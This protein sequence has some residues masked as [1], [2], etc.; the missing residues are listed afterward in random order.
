MLHDHKGALT[1]H[2][3][4][5]FFQ[6]FL[7]QTGS[8]QIFDLICHIW[9]CLPCRNKKIDCETFSEFGVPWEQ[10]YLIFSPM[11]LWTYLSWITDPTLALLV[12]RLLIYFLLVG[13]ILKEE[14]PT[15]L[16]T[17]KI[18]EFEGYWKKNA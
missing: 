9:I 18:S 13:G 1:I 16:L 11:G 2:R 4:C 3:L 12:V 6:F 17:R 7:W 15:L 14:C 10:K 8:T 5:H